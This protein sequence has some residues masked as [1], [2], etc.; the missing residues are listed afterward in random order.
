[1]TES[2][3]IRILIADDHHLI[4]E[5][6][7]AL[8]SGHPDILI[9]GEAADGREAVAQFDRLKP[10]VVL[11]DIQM[12]DMSGLDALEV[13]KAQHPSARVI[14]LTT[15]DGDH[16]AN[17]AITAGAQAYILKSSVRRDLVETI[18]AVY[19]GKKH[20]NA[21]VAAKLSEHASDDALTGRELTV[22]ALI[23][24]GNSNRAI[25]DQLSITE[26]TV[27]GYVKNIL[28][29][30]NANDRTHAVALGIKRGIIEI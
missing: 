1:M 2:K 28:S 21:A 4:R 30:L 5:G 10:D 12:P 26:D 9:V 27:K 15:Y 14:I 6:I 11:L 8:V 17:R 7:A 3:P 29:K 16:L 20:I 24:Q 18:R 22:L 19:R 23:A 13:I 25:G